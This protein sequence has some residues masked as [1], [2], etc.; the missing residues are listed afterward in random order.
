MAIRRREVAPRWHRSGLAGGL[1]SEE[2]QVRQELGDR[3]DDLGG[4][5]ERFIG[6]AFAGPLAGVL[7]ILQLVPPAAQP[8]E[9]T[10]PSAELGA[11]RPVDGM[12]TARGGGPEALLGQQADACLPR[13]VVSQDDAAFRRCPRDHPRSLQRLPRPVQPRSATSTYRKLTSLRAPARSASRHE[14]VVG[15]LVTGGSGDT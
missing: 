10:Q 12:M 8:A 14:S 6:L 7:R 1:A 5:L 15:L 4:C 2:T 3:G 11:D 13:C 9:G